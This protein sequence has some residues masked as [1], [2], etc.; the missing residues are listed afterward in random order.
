MKF[1]TISIDFLIKNY[2]LLSIQHSRSGG[3]LSVKRNQ[4]Y[5]DSECMNT[6]IPKMACVEEL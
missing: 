6:Y 4:S 2:I 3:Q 5:A 1:K